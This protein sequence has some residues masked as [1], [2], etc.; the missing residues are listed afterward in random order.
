MNST[1]ADPTP[2][3]TKEIRS[4]LEEMS[5]S[6][7]GGNTKGR[8]VTGVFDVSMLSKYIAAQAT[9]H[10]EALQAENER[11]TREWQ[12]RYKDLESNLQPIKRALGRQDVESRLDELDKFDEIAVGFTMDKRLSEHLHQRIAEL[13]RHQ[14]RK[15]HHG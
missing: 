2:L 6:L 7:R 8:H 14:E 10:Q 12:Q 15:E 11:V 5:I 3:D 1:S 9:A 13:K 4:D